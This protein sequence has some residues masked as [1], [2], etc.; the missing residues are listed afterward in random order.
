MITFEPIT[1][2]TLYIAKEI[3]NSNK[4]YNLLENGK[5]ERSDTEIREEFLNGK[6]TS[7]FIKADDTY[8]GVADYLLRNPKDG[9]TWIGLFMIHQDYH[10]FCYGTMA[11]LS[12]EEMIAKESTG[13]LRLAV[14]RNNQRAHTFW[15]RLGYSIYGQSEV[16]E[17]LVDCFEKTLPL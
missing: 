6:S 3:V 11:Y 5:A 13:T 8:I 10:G 14:L 1:E 2:E 4:E 16:K 12:F 15:E 17:N 9:L 7:V